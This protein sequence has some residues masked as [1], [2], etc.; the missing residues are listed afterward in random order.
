MND[1]RA[2]DVTKPFS[3][4]SSACASKS[5]RAHVPEKIRWDVRSAVRRLNTDTSSRERAPQNVTASA[6]EE[7]DDPLEELRVPDGVRTRPGSS[8]MC[9]LSC[10]ARWRKLC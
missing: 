1:G 7:L 2:G 8:P 9:E 10:V 6:L 5:G 4:A 3:Q